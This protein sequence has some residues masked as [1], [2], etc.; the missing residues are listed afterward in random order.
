MKMLAI[1]FALLIPVSISAQ[2]PV[3][4]TL[5]V[6]VYSGNNQ[7]IAGATVYFDQLNIKGCKKGNSTR[8][9]ML[10]RVDNYD[11]YNVSTNSKGIAIIKAPL[12]FGSNPST[13]EI[14]KRP[15]LCCDC[16]ENWSIGFKISRVEADGFSTKKVMKEVIMTRQSGKTK[17]VRVVL[18]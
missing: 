15:E 17:S 14:G 3:I 7:P 5:K 18:N 12:C 13:G 4:V 16:N 2:K 10:D 8:T 6:H 11:R 9:V 1:L